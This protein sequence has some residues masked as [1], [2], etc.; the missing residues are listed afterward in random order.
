M[1][2]KILFFFLILFILS[3]NISYSQEK[4]KLNKDDIIYSITVNKD[5]ETVVGEIRDAIIDRNFKITRENEISKGMVYYR[6]GEMYDYKIIEFCNLTLCGDMLKKEPDIG[7]FM[8]TGITIY[9]KG[10]QTV[11]VTKR[12]SYMLN[13]FPNTEVKK[14]VEKLEKEVFEIM[15]SVKK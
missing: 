2:K 3:S 1:H 5:F 15:E 6:G 9:A 7:A 4:A 12:L 13:A 14:E 8:P 10:K 11:L